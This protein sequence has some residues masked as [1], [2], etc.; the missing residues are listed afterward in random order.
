MYCQC[1]KWLM[2]IGWLFVCVHSFGEGNM[3]K[4]FK[5]N[6]LRL[7]QST[8]LFVHFHV[9]A[10]RHLVVLEREE[11]D[12]FFFTRIISVWREMRKKTGS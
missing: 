8:D 9:E 12:A 7:H 5:G 2:M 1:V 6:S 4:A 11:A 3:L 10:V